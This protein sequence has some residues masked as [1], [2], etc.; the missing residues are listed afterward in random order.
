MRFVG[1]DDDVT[2]IAQGGHLLALFRQEFLNSRE[3]YAATRHGEKRAQSLPILC[4]NRCLTENLVTTLK[5]TEQL[6]IEIVAIRQHDERRV[7]HSRMSYDA[8]CVEQH[9]EALPAALRVPDHTSSAIPG[10]SA[11][12]LARPEHAIT[13]ADK[14]LSHPARTNRLRDCCIYGVKLVITGQDFVNVTR[15]GIFFERNEMLQ[16]LKEA[17]ALEHTANEYFELERTFRRIALTVDSAP[18]LEPLLVRS[19]GAYTRLHA[20]RHHHRRVVL[21]K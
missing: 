6:I 19:D 21:N 12:H 20:V 9:R 11:L 8:G 16:Q 7:L 17:V 1:D 5:L 2:T 13:V 18:Y 4:L 15:I 14:L 3:D 10:L